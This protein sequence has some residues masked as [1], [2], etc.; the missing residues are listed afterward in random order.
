MIGVKRMEIRKLATAAERLQAETIC[1]LVFY[2]PL[3][4]D[5][6]GEARDGVVAW[7]ALEDDRV[8][9]SMYAHEYSMCYHGQYYPMFGIGGVG[10][11]AEYRRRGY[12]R[13]IFH[14][15]F[16]EM[17]ARGFVFSYL[18]PFSF[19]YY[20]QFG[21]SL[22]VT[23]QETVLPTGLLKELACGCDAHMYEL[24]DAVEP[25]AE[26]Y[27][28]FAKGYNGMIERPDWKRL[29]NYDAAKKQKFMYLLTKD[30]V[31]KA[32]VAF[33]PGE[34]GSRERQLAVADYAWVDREAMRDLMGFLGGFAAHF[35][36]LR[37]FLPEDISMDW[38]LSDP[39]DVQRTAK[40]YGQLRILNVEK[41]LAGYA[42]PDKA[43]E[44]CIAVR[45][46]YFADNCGTFLVQYG[47]GA[48][49]VEKTTAA[50]QLELDIR[51][52]NPLLFG[53]ASF[54]DLQYMNPAQVAIHGDKTFLKELFPGAPNLIADYF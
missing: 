24:G 34:G 5:A 6:K 20:S 25:Y 28:A 13:R 50:P 11:R 18:Y 43:G 27:S 35:A 53:A 42:W 2:Y 37:I 9:S 36:E 40:P 3:P 41:A 39:Y 51:A 8:I 4:E 26:I 1:S 7:G 45:D 15:I 12:I 44:L 10:T 48:C 32:Y 16:D 23:R 54:D 22:A 14:A 46:D 52:L 21:Y 49:H 17:R 29:E 33:A 30:G 38:L 31:P 47:G 19:A